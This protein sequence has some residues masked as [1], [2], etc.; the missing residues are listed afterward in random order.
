MPRLSPHLISP[1]LSHNS[2]VPPPSSLPRT[3]YSL[4]GR[5]DSHVIVTGHVT[6]A[7]IIEF[8]ADFFHEDVGDHDVRVATFSRVLTRSHAFSRLL[9]P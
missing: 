4:Q 8:S 9:T 5:G 3:D 1:H 6:A 2:H 7:S